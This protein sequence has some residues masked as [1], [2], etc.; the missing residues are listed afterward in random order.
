VH[1]KLSRQ[2][3][4]LHFLKLGTHLTLFYGFVYVQLQSKQLIYMAEMTVEL[5][6]TLEYTHFPVHSYS[7]V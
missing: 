3:Y 2:V 4:Q 6:T 5:C 1:V 7:F